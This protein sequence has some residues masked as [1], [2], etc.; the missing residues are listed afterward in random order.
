MRRSGVSSATSSRP[1]SPTSPETRGVNTMPG[2]TPLARI[3]DGPSSSATERIHD[4]SA[5]FAAPYAAV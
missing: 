2:A 4:M 3:P 1:R 5:A